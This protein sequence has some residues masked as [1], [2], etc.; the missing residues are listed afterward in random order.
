MGDVFQIKAAKFDRLEAGILVDFFADAVRKDDAGG[1]ANTLD[2]G[3][4][5]DGIAKNVAVVEDDFS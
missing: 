4:D 2:S 5:V 1:Y 3:C